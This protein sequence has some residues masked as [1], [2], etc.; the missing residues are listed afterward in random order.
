MGC[1]QAGVLARQRSVHQVIPKISFSGRH[2]Q[3]HRVR[4]DRCP[5]ARSDGGKKFASTPVGVGL[6]LTAASGMNAGLTA[7]SMEVSRMAAASADRGI[8]LP[9]RF[10]RLAGAGSM[11]TT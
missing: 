1:S 3:L 2:R 7:N 8:T 9:R 11:A 6:T 5:L 4:P 10:L